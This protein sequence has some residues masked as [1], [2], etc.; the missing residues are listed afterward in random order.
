VRT[1][2]RKRLWCVM[3]GMVIIAGCAAAPPKDIVLE[4]ELIAA[5]N[6]NPNRQGRASPVTVA[7]FHLKSADAFQSMDFFNLF[8]ADSGA[9][10]ADLIQ[11][12]NMQIQP[13]ESLPIASEFDPET[14]HIGVLAAFRDIDNADWRTVLPLPEKKLTEKL[15]PFSDKRLVVR[16]DDLSVSATVEK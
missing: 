4:G 6:I 2:T 15:N 3:A 13:G 1:M 12:T 10:D 8:D 11:R 5:D 9:I 7:I 16:V 14:T